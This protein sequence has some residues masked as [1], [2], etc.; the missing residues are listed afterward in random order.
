ME[1][2]Q[3]VK[4]DGMTGKDILYKITFLI[5]ITLM[6]PLKAMITNWFHE[7]P[8]NTQNIDQE[9][10]RIL[11][12]FEKDTKTSEDHYIEITTQLK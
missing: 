5:F 7:H 9:I 4:P 2:H 10:N 1:Q 11:Y 3:A 6:I 8:L 12:D